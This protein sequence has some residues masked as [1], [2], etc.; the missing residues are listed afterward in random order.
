MVSEIV[1]TTEVKVVIRHII[2]DFIRKKKTESVREMP[3]G[4]N[5][6]HFKPLVWT[7][8]KFCRVL[9]K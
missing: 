4:S 2:A 9:R 8:S 5:F 3:V 7:D 1:V 6:I